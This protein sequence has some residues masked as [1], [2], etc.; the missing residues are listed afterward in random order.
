MMKT[1]SPTHAIDVGREAKFGIACLL[2]VGCFLFSLV[3]IS[4]EPRRGE[5]GLPQRTAV[6]STVGIGRSGY[7]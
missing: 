7:R 2:E 3:A 5:E 1:E 6:L 4:P